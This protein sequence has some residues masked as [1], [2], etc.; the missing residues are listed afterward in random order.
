VLKWQGLIEEWHDRKIGA[1]SEWARVIDEHLRTADVIL[2]LV[3]T[4]FLASPY[5]YD[6]EMRVA[7]ERHQRGEAHVVPII[8]RPS[9]WK[10]SPLAHLQ[11]VPRDGR[12]IIK[13]PVRDDAWLDVVESLRTLLIGVRRS[14]PNPWRD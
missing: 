6:V 7:L 12:P 5:C 2:L 10:N 1:G 13:W 8:L 3:S 4:P 14:H 9:D 11:V